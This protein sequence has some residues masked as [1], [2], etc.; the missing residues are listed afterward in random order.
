[1]M[2]RQ[3]QFS[4]RVWLMVMSDFN[5]SVREYDAYMKRKYAEDLCSGKTKAESVLDYWEETTHP[6][7][8][9]RPILNCNGEPI[10]SDG[11]DIIYFSR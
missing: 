9:I 3:I 4:M 11:H 1:M 6:E 7:P 8:A 10:P 2:L 5:W